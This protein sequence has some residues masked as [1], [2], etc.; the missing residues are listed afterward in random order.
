[1]FCTPSDNGIQTFVAVATYTLNGQTA[2]TSN[3]IT[4]GVAEAIATLGARIISVHTHDNH[5]LKDEHLWPGDGTIDWTAAAKGLKE[6]AA[7]P[8]IVLEIGHSLNDDNHA[9]AAKIEQGFAR[10]E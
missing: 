2:Y 7:P 8:A 1:M 4:V 5:G 10:F 3:Y 9:I 6:L